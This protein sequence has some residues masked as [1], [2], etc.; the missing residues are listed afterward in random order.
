MQCG[1]RSSSR[2]IE[3]GGY[4][5]FYQCF[6]C[7]RQESRILFGIVPHVVSLATRKPFPTDGAGVAELT[8]TETQNGGRLKVRVG[9]TIVLCL[10]ELAGTGYRWTVASLDEAHV[11]LVEQSYQSVGTALGGA[12]VAVWRLETTRPGRTRVQ[13]EKSRPWEP[14]DAVSQRFAVDLEVAD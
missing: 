14:G 4:C 7:R 6:V 13:L 3:P 8:V 5:R 1:G 9:D 11:R 10:P 2:R 12:G